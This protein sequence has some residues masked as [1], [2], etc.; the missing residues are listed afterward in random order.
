MSE[1]T[2]MEEALVETRRGYCWRIG[3]AIKIS[4]PCP[5]CGQKEGH[6][7]FPDQMACQDFSRCTTSG[8]SDGHPCE[9]TY[10]HEG[11]CWNSCGSKKV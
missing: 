7:P 5:E 11:P 4:I 9:G 2:E 1:I 10:G 3:H 6:A 8:C